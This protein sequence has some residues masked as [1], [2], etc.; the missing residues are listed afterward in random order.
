VPRA[1]LPRLTLGLLAWLGADL[2]SAAPAGP[3]A[4]PPAG[5]DARHPLHPSDLERKHQGAY[6]TA[7]PLADHDPNT[8]FGFGARGYYYENGNRADPLFAYTP[9]F[10]RLFLQAYATTGGLQF[11][12]F[13]VDVPS[14]DRGP[15]RFRAQIIFNRNL[16][17]HYF[18]TGTRTLAPLRYPGTVRRFK[19]F[20]DY[21][22]ALNQIENGQTRSRYD[23]YDLL[24]PAVLVGLERS[25]LYGIL[26]PLIGVGLSYTRIRDYSGERVSVPGT[27]ARA[28]MG[29]TRLSEDCIWG[30]IVGCDG[31]FNNFL[32]LGMSLDTRDYE[33]DP[34]QGVYVDLAFDYG[35]HFLGSEYEWGRAMVSPRFYVSPLAELV[36]LV[37]AVRLTGQLQTRSTP[38]FAMKV[39]P[40]IDDFHTGLGGVKT[41]RGY[42]QDR[43]VGTLMLL[44]NAELRWTFAGFDVLDQRIRLM[45]VPFVDVGG[46]Y[47]GVTTMDMLP[48]RRGQGFALRASWN[49]ATIVTTEYGFSDEDDGLYVNFNHQF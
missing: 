25:M 24:Q 37:L 42:R 12:W 34:N 32:R 21:Q 47:D 49:L 3:P 7:L 20:D 15:F 26:R 6:F 43:F 17:E 45:A 9:Y 11:H 31:G 16:D 35:T 48:P 22:R 44:G 27:D 13:D 18:G 19:R 28:T 36:D 14:I 23:S 4:G 29:P 39:I 10:L 30:S 41:L 8:G 33:P 1:W 38:F 40:Y 46:A 5:L 2:V